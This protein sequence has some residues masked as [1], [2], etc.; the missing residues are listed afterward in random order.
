MKIAMIG[1]KGIPAISGGVEK[2]VEEIAKRLAL[3]GNEVTVFNRPHYCRFLENN[4]INNIKIKEVPSINTK[5]LDAISHTFNCSILSLF[6]KFDVIH[7]HA[8]GPSTLSFIPRLFGKKVVVTVHGLDWQRD[9]WS[10]GAKKLLRLGEFTS[11]YFPHK[12]IT[13]S[14]V[15]KKYYKD[16]YNIEAVP[17]PN[18]VEIP[19][20]LPPRLIKKEYGLDSKGY[21]LFLARLVP[22]KGVHYLLEAYSKLDVPLKLVVAG[23]SSN[24]DGY[25]KTLDKYKNDSRIIFTGQVSGQKLKE[26][27]SNAYLYVLPSDL[28]GL[29]ISLL[30]AMSYKIPCLISNIPENLEVGEDCMLTFEKSNANELYQKINYAVNNPGILDSLSKKAFNKVK[31]YYDWERVTQ[32]TLSVYQSLMS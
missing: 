19:K 16:K 26:L 23:G 7:Y 4:F 17:I 32:E 8:I 21:I 3:L 9:K 6:S 30:E 20:T 18:G 11:A 31:K 25:V 27:F 13:V 15:L 14:N 2:H 1:Q 22:E 29:P 24:S 10:K 12:L 28:E 5:H